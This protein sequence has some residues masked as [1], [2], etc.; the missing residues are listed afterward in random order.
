MTNDR[1]I[2]KLPPPRPP[3]CDSFLWQPKQ[4]ETPT[5][6]LRSQRTVPSVAWPGGPRLRTP[7]SLLP[8]P[9]TTSYPLLWVQ[10]DLGVKELIAVTVLP[11]P[12]GHQF[13]EVGGIA[14]EACGGSGDGQETLSLQPLGRLPPFPAASHC[15]THKPCL[16]SSD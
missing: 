10:E 7:Q 11:L 5:Q 4:T 3:V 12:L 1:V 14:N 16:F 8:S 9:P 15:L 13:A 6:R 2:L